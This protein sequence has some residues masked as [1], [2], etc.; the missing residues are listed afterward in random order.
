V[1]TNFTVTF[2]VTFYI[3]NIFR[4]TSYTFYIYI[5]SLISAVPCSKNPIGSDRKESEY[6]V[7]V[8]KFQIMYIKYLIDFYI[9]VSFFII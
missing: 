6:H 5:Q 8:R 4:I 2:I 9:S 3:L 7:F 1:V